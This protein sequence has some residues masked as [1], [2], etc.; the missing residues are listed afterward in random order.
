MSH[1]D[2]CHLLISLGLGFGTGV[3]GGD[4]AQKENSGRTPL[5]PSCREPPPAPPE[6]FPFSEAAFPVVANW[7]GHSGRA[8]VGKPGV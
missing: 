1:C 6:C 8:G 4:L 5:P 7:T 2:P 3:G